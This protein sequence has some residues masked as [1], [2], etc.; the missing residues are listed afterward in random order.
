MTMFGFLKAL[1]RNSDPV[2]SDLAA[3][4]V[5]V[6]YLEGVVLRTLLYWPAGLSCFEIANSTGLELGSITPRMKPL[7]A[8]GL[9]YREGTRRHQGQR[10]ARIVWKAVP[11]QEKLL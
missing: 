11:V 9:I 1:S 5:D 4:L 2:T 7:E 10:N 3:E 6:T 8:K